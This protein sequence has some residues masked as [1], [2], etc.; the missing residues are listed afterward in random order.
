[1]DSASIS[2]RLG[3]LEL[4]FA[5][6]LGR[7]DPSL[8]VFIRSPIVRGLLSESTVYSNF[9]ILGIP[10]TEESSCKLTCADCRLVDAELAF[11]VIPSSNSDSPQPA[12]NLAFFVVKTFL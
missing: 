3:V 12:Q 11:L 4:P 6:F 8:F 7:S 5:V 1:M 10:Y 2:S 9:S